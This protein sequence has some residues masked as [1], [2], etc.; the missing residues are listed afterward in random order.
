LSDPKSADGMNATERR[1]TFALGG[2]V[3][4]RMLGLFMILPVLALYAERYDG[5]TPTLAGLAI[6]AYGLT[7]AL[8]QIPFGALSDRIGRRPVI[9]TGLLIFA[10]GSAVAAMSDTI[11]GLIIGR[12]L[13]G[14]GAISAAVMALAA[15]LTREE[16]RTKTMAGIG[17]SVGLAFAVA[18]VVG[19]AVAHWFG[20]SALFLLTATLALLGI[21]VLLLYVPRAVACHFH[22]DAEPVPGQFGRILADGQ[23]LRLDAGIL[24]LHLIL[25]SSFVVLPLVL[26]DQ[27]GLAP[28]DHWHVYLLVL[29]IS[30]VLMAPFVMYGERRQQVKTIFM[31]AIGLLA[32]SQLG[33]YLYHGDKVQIALMMVLFFVGLNVL[34]ATLPS[35]ISRLAPPDMKGTAL[36]VY[37]TSQFLGAFLGGLCGGWLHHHFGV[38]GVFAFCGTLA[39]AWLL[40]AAGMRNPRSLSSH[41]LNVGHI[42]E[43]QAQRLATELRAIA[44]V[45]EAV[46]VVDDG[47]AYLKVDRKNLDLQALR[48]FSAAEA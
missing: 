26:R 29:A 21:A 45:A 35:L 3:A 14:A 39:C 15:D 24:I 47:V 44:G 16:H 28:E 34:E 17:A 48:A 13:Q 40:F 30:V 33:L 6:G 41:L 22:R 11:A 37:S 27:G 38:E 18:L 9:V 43:A 2:I 42:T 10:A 7:Q 36:G 32:L 46:V 20:M 23:L 19:P 31:G 1:A 25:T 5:Y 8:F 12:A 4:L